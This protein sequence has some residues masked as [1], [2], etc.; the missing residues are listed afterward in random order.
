MREW[1]KEREGAKERMREGEK[2]RWREGERR[3]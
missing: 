2:D 1:G 3:A